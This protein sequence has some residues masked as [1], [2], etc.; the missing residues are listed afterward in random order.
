MTKYYCK[1]CL[2]DLNPK[3]VMEIVQHLA[4]DHRVM[5]KPSQAISESMGFIE[6]EQ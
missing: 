1:L 6:I 5:L 2:K 4:L 3:F